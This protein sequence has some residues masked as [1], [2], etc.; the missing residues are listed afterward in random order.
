[1]YFKNAWTSGI[2]EL[3]SMEH[4]KPASVEKCGVHS[5]WVKFVLYCIIGVANF[6][7][8]AIFVAMFTSNSKVVYFW[9]L[10]VS[11][12]Q[13]TVLCAYIYYM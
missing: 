1:M 10:L 9:C 6:V 4:H 11:C 12:K 13:P 7:G 8:G 5:A 3:G 2:V